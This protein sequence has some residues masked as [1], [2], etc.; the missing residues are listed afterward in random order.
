MVLAYITQRDRL[1]VF[2]H[3]VFAEAGIQ[4][5]GGT[6]NEYETPEEAVLRE[7]HEETGLRDLRL[8]ALLGEYDL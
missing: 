5:P 1:L 3:V 6:Q 8:D 7:A 2:R 4:V